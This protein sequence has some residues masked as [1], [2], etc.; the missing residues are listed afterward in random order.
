MYTG[1]LP[2]RCLCSAA[3]SVSRPSRP[4]RIRIPPPGGAVKLGDRRQ[5]LRPC[6]GVST[7]WL[8]DATTS[9]T[10]SSARSGYRSKPATAVVRHVVR[11]S[12]GHEL[13]AV[14][15]EEGHRR[16]L[17]GDLAGTWTR[18][19]KLV[20]EGDDVLFAAGGQ[21]SRTRTSCRGEEHA[22]CTRG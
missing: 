15:P 16:N 12:C 18:V 5:S 11:W 3:R 10:W 8:Q 4:A 21:A 7:L 22:R 9:P 6:A 19:A 13:H 14:V 20:L 2:L 1:I 17:V